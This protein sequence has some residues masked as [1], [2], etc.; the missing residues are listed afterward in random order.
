MFTLCYYVRDGDIF[1]SRSPEGG[2]MACAEKRSLRPGMDLPLVLAAYAALVGSSALAWEVLGWMRSR[3]SH[4]IVRYGFGSDDPQDASEW[5]VAFVINQGT[6]PARL[7]YW[8]V[9]NPGAETY[10]IL[11]IP[12][13]DAVI[14]P[15]DVTRLKALVEDLPDV[16]EG[17]TV[18]VW[19]ELTTGEEF[20]SESFTWVPRPQTAWDPRRTFG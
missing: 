19:V 17:E 4:I 2:Q 5:I 1:S 12:P 13:R 8:G 15:G 11:R 3:R 7:T 14:A 9:F 10:V 20:R 16:R 18:A 6:Q